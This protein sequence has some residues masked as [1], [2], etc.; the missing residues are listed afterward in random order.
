M[1]SDRA[2]EILEKLRKSGGPV[3]SGGDLD[4][5]RERARR[6]YT[7]VPIEEAIQGKTARTGSGVLWLVERSAGDAYPRSR[8]L[9]KRCLKAFEDA[10]LAVA[11]ER[12]HSEIL[13]CL[14]A[15]PD[16]LLFVDVETT[17]LASGTIFLVGAMRWAGDRFIIRQFFA[18]DYT[19]EPAILAALAADAASAR[20]LVT[21]N[22][23]SFDLP[24]LEERSRFHGI[25]FR[26]R[27]AHCDLLH[28]ARRQWKTILPDCRLKTLEALV[29]GMPRGPDISGREIPSTYHEY[30]KT[31]D[32]RRMI[33]I[34]H[35]NARDLV[36][37][38][39]LLLSVI[40]GR[41]PE[42]DAYFDHA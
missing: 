19:E 31:K 18:R 21:F 25:N 10:P 11:E 40:E 8:E 17:G 9:E 27:K 20:V 32:A 4:L 37:M 26:W 36:S 24:S 30:V 41:V 35:H 16:R 12:Y 42:H 7:P 22:G 39:D 28:E 38:A 23:K 14:K 6:Q 5:I 3:F 34:V 15:G 33:A 2:R 1:T 29:C 13:D